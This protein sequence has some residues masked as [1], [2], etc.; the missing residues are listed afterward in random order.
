M[1]DIAIN[2]IMTTDPATVAPGDPISVAKERLESGQIHHL[3]VVE[4]GALV[5]IVSTSDLLKFHMLDGDAAALSS[6]TVAQIMEPEPVV[7]QSDASLRDAAAALSI[8]GYHALPVVEPDHTLVGI[9]TSVD[10]VMYLLQQL[11][12][13]DGSIRDDGDSVSGAQV[14]DSVIK[15]VIQQAE[16][17]VLQ[18][19]GAQEQ[20][21]VLL[22][23]RDRNRLL[24][25]MRQAA[26]HYMRSGHGER[27]HSVLVKQLSDL[28][29]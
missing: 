14:S 16:Q 24:E 19:S 27:E 21:R 22:H 11:P 28:Q 8:G 13:G 3:P 23:L 25:G 17:D 1:R 12:R 4:N 7:L 20:A 10:L 5:G 26:E 29:E 9:V 15:Q 18:G 6:T 2:R